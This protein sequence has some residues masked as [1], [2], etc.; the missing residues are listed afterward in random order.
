MKTVIFIIIGLII[1]AAGYAAGSL[2]LLNGFSFIPKP[3]VAGTAKLE[4]KLLMDNG[5]PVAKVEIDVGE[6]PGPPAVGGA[7]ATD[8]RGVATFM[9]KPGTYTVYF[10][11]GT[12]PQN[13]EQPGLR[14]VTVEEGKTSQVTL[15]VK[16]K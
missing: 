4:V 8:E 9:L 11:N 10:N 3:S 12:W 5:T 14:Q 6:Q 16:T 1:F 7:M 2:N 13:L 15:T